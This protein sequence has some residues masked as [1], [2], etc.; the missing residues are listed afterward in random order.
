MVIKPVAVLLTVRNSYLLEEQ[1]TSELLFQID[2]KRPRGGEFLKE[3]F[4]EK[5]GNTVEQPGQII[6]KF[7]GSSP[8]NCRPKPGF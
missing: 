3:A 6:V 4:L 8:Q 5:G 1:G 7:I 2:F